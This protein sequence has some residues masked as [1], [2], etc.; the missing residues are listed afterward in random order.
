M[1]SRRDDDLAPAHSETDDPDLGDRFWGQV[2][3]VS[4]LF[5]ESQGG[6]RNGARTGLD[7]GKQG[8]KRASADSPRHQETSMVRRG[9]TVRVR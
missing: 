9:S 8:G 3:V 1:I 2:R 6:D 4:R 7:T 5:R